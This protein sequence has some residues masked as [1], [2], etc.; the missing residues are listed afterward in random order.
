VI[1][2]SVKYLVRQAALTQPVNFIDIPASRKLDSGLLSGLGKSTVFYLNEAADGV[3]VGGGNLFENGE[4]DA[5][6]VA[7]EALQPPLML[8]SNS[9]GRIVGRAG[10]FITRSDHASKSVLQRLVN[11]SSYALSRDSMT[12]SFLRKKF[13]CDT[14]LGLCP[15]IHVPDAYG[16]TKAAGE[17]SGMTYLS[18][19]NPDRISGV[20]FLKYRVADAVEQVIKHY[21]EQEKLPLRILCNDLRDL[22]YAEYLYQRFGVEYC[23]TSDDREFVSI[24]HCA[25]AVI[26][27]RL[28]TSIPCFSLGVPLVNLSYDERAL[29][30]VK[31]LGLA[32]RNLSIHEMDPQEVLPHIINILEQRQESNAEMWSKIFQFQMSKME[33]FIGDCRTYQASF[34]DD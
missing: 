34:I 14:D 26:S 9:Y 20:E 30:L 23:Y 24:L 6:E 15:T 3:I 19:R 5:D 28:H 25:T 27:F 29:S 21:Q 22:R 4:I 13:E 31:D 33:E 8:F 11:K 16:L 1:N 18:I 17:E 32:D 2:R 7:L 12:Q 10:K